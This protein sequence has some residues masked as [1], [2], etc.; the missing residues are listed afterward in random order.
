MEVRNDS[1]IVSIDSGGH[2]E[3]FFARRDAL[4]EGHLGLVRS[5]A[6]SIKR[7]VPVCFDLDDLIAAGNVALT[8]AATRYR[9]SEHGDA[10]FDAYAR[11]VIR[12]AILDTVRRREYEE[13]TR[14]G[15]ED[16]PEPQMA[17]VVETMIDDGR[18]RRRVLD[19]VAQL[20]AREKAIL[21]E[22]YGPAEPSLRVVGERIGVSARRAAQLHELAVDKLRKILR[23]A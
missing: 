21:L 2:R 23:S 15:L 17:P 9:P 1:N 6:I 16:A 7:S 18:L 4:V 19:A 13:S 12:G 20:P 22:Y 3:R 8:T 14:P 11:Q 10:P 5:I